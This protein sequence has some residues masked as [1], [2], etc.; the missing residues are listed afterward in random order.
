M[1]PPVD[2]VF[3]IPLFGICGD[4]LQF[5]LV[6]LVEGKVLEGRVL[7]GKELGHGTNAVV[8]QEIT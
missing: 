7:G 1:K 5:I 6:L 3:V 8:L 4:S 2:L